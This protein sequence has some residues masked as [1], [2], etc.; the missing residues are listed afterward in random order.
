MVLGSSWMLQG[1]VPEVADT[2]GASENSWG[3]S[4]HEVV[5][6]RQ[7]AHYLAQTIARVLD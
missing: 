6:Q 3:R 4:A 7:H 2:K 5:G 1:F